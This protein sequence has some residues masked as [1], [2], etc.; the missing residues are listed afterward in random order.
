MMMQHQD[1][2]C[3]P[4]SSFDESSIDEPQAPTF[5]R[6]Y[7]RGDPSLSSEDDEFSC[8][9]ENVH[10]NLR[11][12]LVPTYSSNYQA[13]HTD[14]FKLD[15]DPVQ[16]RKRCGVK[17]LDSLESNILCPSKKANVGGSH[18]VKGGQKLI[19]ELFDPKNEEAMNSILREASR[20]GF[21]KTLAYPNR[22][23]WVKTKLP[24][25]FGSGGIL[26]G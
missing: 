4:S 15:S 14:R 7:A 16:G 23:E 26:A 1:F 6:D 17:E 19:G 3:H 8:E 20:E 24:I 9:D 5:R 2:Y 12:S 11:S 10:D 22:T 18:V 13:L 25:W 21:M